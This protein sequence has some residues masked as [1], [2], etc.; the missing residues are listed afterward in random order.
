M[1][2][3]QFLCAEEDGAG[4]AVAPRL[5]T[6]MVV[7]FGFVSAECQFFDTIPGACPALGQRHGLQ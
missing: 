5:A 3:Q 7:K 6:G 2:R 4:R 1:K